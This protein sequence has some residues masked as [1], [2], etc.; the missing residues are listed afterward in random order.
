MGKITHYQSKIQSVIEN[1][2]S[3]AQ[4]REQALA[5]KSFSYVEK[6]ETSARSY[7][8]TQLKDQYLNQSQK[9]FGGLRSLN[10]RAGTVAA[11]IVTR[12]E[13]EVAQMKT[14]FELPEGTFDIA[15][16]Q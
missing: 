5:S 8:V 16:I 13:A 2:I 9:V 11:G 6:L 3:K 15:D 4:A 10:A 7:S 12:I 14:M 1:G